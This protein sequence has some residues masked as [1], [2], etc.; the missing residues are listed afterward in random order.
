MGDLGVG[1]GGLGP[2]KPVQVHLAR[3]PRATVSIFQIYLDQIY[4][5]SL[6]RLMNNIFMVILLNPLAPHTF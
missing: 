6:L 4:F 3:P 2:A 1:P 5:D